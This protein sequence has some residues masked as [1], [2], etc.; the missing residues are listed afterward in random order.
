M[1]PKSKTIE[2]IYQKLTPIEHIL[3]RPDSYIG[4]LSLQ[5]DKQYVYENEKINF[6]FF[7]SKYLVEQPRVQS[8]SLSYIFTLMESSRNVLV[9]N[10]PAL[11]LLILGILSGFVLYLA[12]FGGLL[13]YLLAELM[14]QISSI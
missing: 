11:I 9:R 2:E 7:I 1:P 14:I 4:S 12:T 8:L 3:K 10:L 6:L 5:K 13:S